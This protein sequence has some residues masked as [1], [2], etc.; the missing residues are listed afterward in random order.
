MLSNYPTEHTFL[1]P[2]SLNTCSKIFSLHHEHIFQNRKV[3]SK[4]IGDLGAL[5]YSYYFS[6]FTLPENAYSFLSS[7]FSLNLYS[8]PTLNIPV[9]SFV[10]IHVSKQ[11]FITLHIFLMLTWYFYPYMFFTSPV[12]HTPYFLLGNQQTF[13]H[14]ILVM[15]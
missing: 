4:N 15:Y 11:Y 12:C 13:F 6:S 9:R 10:F 2:T 3:L 5:L 14:K 1:T 8:A 7:N